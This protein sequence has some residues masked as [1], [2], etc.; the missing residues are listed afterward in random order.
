MSTDDTP[1][2]PPTELVHVDGSLLL[3]NAVNDVQQDCLAVARISD[4]DKSGRW[5]VAINGRSGRTLW[6]H[7]LPVDTGSKMPELAISGSAVLVRTSKMLVRLRAT[8]GEVVWQTPTI[9]PVE[10]TRLCAT[11][12]YIAESGETAPTT[13]WDWRSGNTLRVKAGKCEPLYSTRSGGSNFDFAESGDLGSVVPATKNFA[14][15]RGLVPHQGIAR[16]ILGERAGDSQTP[17]PEVGV[18]TSRRWVWQTELGE[19]TFA[20]FPKPPI[21]AVRS[22]RLVVPYL[23]PKNQVLRMTAFELE[24]GKRVWDITLAEHAAVTS[25]NDM[26]VVISLD[27]A[28]FVKTFDGRLS[29]FALS[30]GTA[31]W[32]IGGA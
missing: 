9:G 26:G 1:S 6:R 8:D 15:L 16:V 5:L 10:G 22:G 23:D 21:A 31:L 24:R 32:S 25:Q 17:N 27:G 4:A 30:T 28:V 12:T 13:G 19:D 3:V 20:A 29:A 18:V 14:T 7:P 2:L 11:N